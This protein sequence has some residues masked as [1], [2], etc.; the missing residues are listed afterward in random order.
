MS[1]LKHI[2][3]HLLVLFSLISFA[4]NA[5]AGDCRKVGE[6]CT[7]P[8]GTRNIGGT[9]VYAPCWEYTDK[10]ECSEAGG[11]N[12]CAAISSMRGCYQT[13]SVCIT[14]DFNNKCIMY[15]KTFRCGDNVGNPVGTVRLDD[16]HTIVTD[17]IDRSQ[18]DT[19][20]NNNSC[21]SAG[22]V[23]IEGAGTRTVDGVPVYKDCWK[24]RE[25]FTCIAQDNR[26]YCTP[27]R[28][29]CREVAQ[30]CVQWAWNGTCNEYRRTFRCDNKVGDPLPP[31][32]VYL[33]TEYTVT[34][35]HP[36]MSQCQQFADNPNCKLASHVCVQPGGTRVINGL[37]VYK[38]CWEWKD[39]YTCASETL[40]SDCQDLANNPACKYQ[41]STCLDK[42]PGGQ[43]GVKEN[44]YQCVTKESSSTTETQCRTGVCV[45]G[46]CD[47]P[48]D[49]PDADFGLA[50]AGMEAGREAGEYMDPDTMQIFK[51]IAREC[52]VKLG[53]VVNCCK[54]ETMG[55][56]QSNALMAG[57]TKFIWGEAR[58]YMGSA[59]V[60]DALQGSGMPTAILSG[61]Y[62]D[63]PV[64]DANTQFGSGFSFYG[65]TYTPGAAGLGGLPITFD[66][67]SFAFAVA[68]QVVMTYMQCEVEEQQLGMQKG[69]RLCVHVGSYCGTKVLG[70]C[71]TKKESY[72]C[73]NSRLARILNEQGRPQ[74]G[75]G[76]GDPKE[77][78]C[79]GFT[80]AEL[81][82][83]D[84]SAMDLSE[85]IN[86]VSAGTLD[87]EAIK[88]R[89]TG[90]ATGKMPTVDPD[91]ALGYYGK[92]TPST[93]K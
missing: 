1:Y 73:Y 17:T 93:P 58:R 26:D 54:V 40:T 77:P 28:S 62:G 5:F 67:Y 60:Y 13:G 91:Q 75:K 35:D 47:A 27:L 53:G 12:Y 70:A 64:L 78:N 90:R 31:N 87:M 66:P 55:G 57:A 88:E 59:Y 74:I 23:C 43:C 39:D 11:T 34:N 84:M 65:F 19:Y 49:T 81:Q 48:K 33:N 2:I 83:L 46:S 76:W 21:K 25:D 37:P 80:I 32:V 38:D 61:M 9:D 42:L 79:S 6:T 4:G 36:D 24:W 85:F 89:M 86:E 72:C 3:A 16:S 92:T 20:S 18:C 15:E 82:Q 52:S 7:Q 50:V 69:Q 14:K 22:Q 45:A 8:G 41:S 71:I 63:V 56:N 51:G 68:M 44:T 29:V 10:Y 30:E